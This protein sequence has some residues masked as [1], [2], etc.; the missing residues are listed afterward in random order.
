M[1]PLK[2]LSAKIAILLA[3]FALPA[4][5]EEDM[6]KGPIEISFVDEA[7]HAHALSEFRGK[8]VLLNIWA[9]WCGPC[10][11]EMPSLAHLNQDYTR[12]NLVV[13]PVSEDTQTSAILRFYASKGISG[14]PIY[15]DKDMKVIPTLRL[16]GLPTTLLLDKD[17]NSVLM[18]TGQVD[19]DSTKARSEIDQAM[20]AHPGTPHAGPKVI[21]FP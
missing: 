13:L 17:S 8:F 3:C 2:S 11:A 4:L 15:R 19:W 6:P 18:F 9:S 21:S 20:N 10:V 16:S 12:Q 14:L 5:A 1:R 7:D